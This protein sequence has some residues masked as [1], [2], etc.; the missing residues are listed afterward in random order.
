MHKNL[1]YDYI[2]TSYYYNW[3]TILKQTNAGNI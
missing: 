3:K 1:D 2:F